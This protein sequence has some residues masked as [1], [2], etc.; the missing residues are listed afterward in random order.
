MTNRVAIKEQIRE[1]KRTL[2]EGEMLFA[3]LIRSNSVTRDQ[4]D[5]IRKRRIAILNTL[6]WVDKNRTRIVESLTNTK[7]GKP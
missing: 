1:A 2:D 7:R 5:L 4:V 3:K 6:R